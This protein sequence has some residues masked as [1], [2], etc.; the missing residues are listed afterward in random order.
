M[1]ITILALN[2]IA[3]FV[4]TMRYPWRAC[5]RGPIGAYR[6]RDI[7][8]SMHIY[9]FLFHIRAMQAENLFK[10]VITSAVPTLQP[11]PQLS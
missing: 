11:T 3:T 10:N 2:E 8:T 1:Y 4:G 9:C 5:E 6:L 7:Y